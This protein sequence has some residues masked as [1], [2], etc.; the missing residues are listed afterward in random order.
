MP[1]MMTPIDDDALES[2]ETQDQQN[3]RGGDHDNYKSQN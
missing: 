2:N 3:E 1:G